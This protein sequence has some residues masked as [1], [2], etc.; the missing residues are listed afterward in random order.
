MNVQELIQE[1]GVKE[2]EHVVVKTKN[3]IQFGNRWLEKGEPILYFD[4][5]QMSLLSENSRMIA[6]RGGFDNEPRVIWEN[7]EDTVFQFTNGTLNQHSLALLLGAKF[8][9]EQPPVSIPFADKGFEVDE[10]GKVYLTHTPDTSKKM[11]FYI[12]DRDNL[13]VRIYPTSIV[14]NVVTFENQY[15]GKKIVADYYFLYQNDIL[16]YTLTRERLANLYTV[17]AT[18]YL[19]DENDGLLHSGLIR[20]PKAYI[21]SNIN[22]RMGERADPMVSTFNVIAMPDSQESDENMICEIIL[23]EDDITGI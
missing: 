4:H 16:T 20:M 15:I 18:F 8:A 11:F 6:A 13:Q 12:E 22:L 21:A 2:L 23:F 5:I 7:R 14:E 17:E 3:D 19:K 9:E 10:S 1:F